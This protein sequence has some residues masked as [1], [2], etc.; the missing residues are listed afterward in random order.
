M[1]MTRKDE[2]PKNPQNPDPVA[3]CKSNYCSHETAG[4]GVKICRGGELSI[5]GTQ[6]PKQLKVQGGQN[7]EYK[8]RRACSERSRTKKRGRGVYTYLR[9]S[10]SNFL[11]SLGKS[12]RSDLH[13]SKNE[14][15][16]C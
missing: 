10:I 13:I 15:A 8:L 7:K 4:G 12:L 11:P 9:F 3:R 6:K 14:E 1:T 16:E 2:N 5:Q